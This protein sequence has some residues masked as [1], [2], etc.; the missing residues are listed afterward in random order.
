MPKINELKL[1]HEIG[2]KSP[3]QRFIYAPCKKCGTPR[4]ALY[5]KKTNRP[6]DLICAS[7]GKGKRKGLFGKGH[8]DKDGYMFKSLPWDHPYIST[9]NGRGWIYEH[10]LVM[11]QHLGRNLLPHELVHHLNEIRD[12][13]RIENL[14]L[15]SRGAHTHLEVP[16]KERIQDLERT[17]KVLEA[18]IKI[19]ESET[20]PTQPDFH[21]EA[22][23]GQVL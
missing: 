12:D 2:K 6:R 3:F 13:N 4:W 22:C 16:Y 1:G 5:V 21:Y 23:G 11:A 8:Y 20:E 10:R 18:R 14:A 17:V 15:M 7:C 19:L 9:A